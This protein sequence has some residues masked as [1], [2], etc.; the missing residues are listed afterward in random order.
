M[1]RILK[2]DL[3]EQYTKLETIPTYYNVTKYIVVKKN[4]VYLIKSYISLIKKLHR[5]PHI[6]LTNVL[7]ILINFLLTHDRYLMKTYTI[8][9][10]TVLQY[11]FVHSKTA[12]QNKLKNYRFK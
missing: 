5:I 6:F 1:R 4:N 7:H 11:S 2:F 8:I 3:S 9:T 12:F 10:T